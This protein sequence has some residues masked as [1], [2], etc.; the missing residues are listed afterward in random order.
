MNVRISFSAQGVFDNGTIDDGLLAFGVSLEAFFERKAKVFKFKS[1][2]LS[3][4]LNIKYTTYSVCL[5]C[6][7]SNMREYLSS[8]CSCLQAALRD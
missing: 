3:W 1:I 4:C 6:F 7:F 5:T 8:K 2:C